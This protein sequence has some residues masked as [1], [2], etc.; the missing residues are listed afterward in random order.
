M[1]YPAVI[2]DFGNVIGFFDYAR[3][4]S[5]IARP[6]GLD[7]PE[8]FHRAQEAG[9]IQLVS[10]LEVGELAPEPFVRELLT[11]IGL[12]E[13]PIEECSAAWSDI[14]EPNEAIAPLV[15]RLHDSGRRLIL[16]SNTNRLHSDRFRRQFS[17]LLDRFDHLVLSFEIG[18]L[19]PSIEFY[20]ACVEA[21][22]ASPSEC[23][24]IDDLPENVE[25]ARQLGLRGITYRDPQ[26]LEAELTA[27]GLLEAKTTP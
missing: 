23:L 3:A 14:F 18:H 20:R 13:V 11:R 1:R 21:S 22:G 6:R 12:D 15:Q 10:R 25:G 5:A 8:L 4:F 9:L 19:K 2:F 26:A 27:L 16:G 24:F 7:G 17:G